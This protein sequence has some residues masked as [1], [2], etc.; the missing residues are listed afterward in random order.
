MEKYAVI[1]AG[2]AGSRLWPLSRQDKPKQFICVSGGKCML[3]ETIE[4]ICQIVAPEKCFVIT[5]RDLLDITCDTLKNLI[6]LSNIISEPARKNTAA[7]IAYA[8]MLLRKNFGS[9]LIGFI[10]ADGC[11]K[12]H[13][14]YRK[15]IEAGY[16]AAESTDSMVV[17]GIAPAYPATGY[18]YI[19]FG[20]HAD[21]GETFSK[22]RGFIEKP[23]AETAKKLVASGEFFWNSGIL[24]GNMDTIIGNIKLFLPEHFIKISEALNHIGGTD[25][26]KYIEKAFDEIRDISFDKGVLE[27][28]VCIHAVKGCFDWDDI[29]SLDSISKMLEPDDMGNS[30]NGTHFGI[31]TADSVIYGDD[32]LIATI[33]IKN[34]IIACTK[35]AII[36]CPRNKAQ[37]VRQLVELLKL[38]GYENY[39]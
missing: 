6:P 17:I 23:D 12:D 13:A 38:N 11:V 9:G 10:P 24:L 14:G 18:G 36:V 4:R 28:S 15:A 33:D 29:G 26:E 2:G 20:Q 35:D 19:R 3:V 1:M 27:K 16:L 22:V 7:C 25:F 37:D 30:T 8:S 31:G 34:M 5:N 32:V 21:S 39:V